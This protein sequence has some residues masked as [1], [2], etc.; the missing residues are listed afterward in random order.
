MNTTLNKIRSHSPRADG[1][2][3]LLKHLGKTQADDEPLSIV[4][5]LESNGFDDAIWCLRAVDGYD[6][7]IRLYGIW[8]ARQTH[9]FITSEEA[10]NAIDVA[11]RYAKG[12]ASDHE[13]ASAWAE[14][15]SAVGAEEREAV[16]ATAYSVARVEAWKAASEAVHTSLLSAA[17]AAELISAQDA[18]EQELLRVCACIDEGVEPY[19]Q[20]EDEEL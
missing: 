15:R 12:L 14:A 8:C 9:P 11:E 20:N 2:T 4:T 3:K 10:I 13:L 17:W 7:E 19:P 5:L 16:L 1:W 6:K 18:Q